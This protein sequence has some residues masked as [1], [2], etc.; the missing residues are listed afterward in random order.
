[1][2]EL[3]LDRVLFTLMPERYER[4]SMLITSNLVFSEWDRTFKNLM[5]TAAAIERF[6]HHCVI[7]EFDVPTFRTE[8]AKTREGPS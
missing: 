8:D 4:A 7:L 1:M 6:V 2:V 3:P 5:T